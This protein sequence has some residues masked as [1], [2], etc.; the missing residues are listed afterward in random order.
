MLIV[1]MGL[2]LFVLLNAWEGRAQIAGLTV[3]LYNSAHVSPGDLVLAEERAAGIFRQAKIKINWDLVPLAG[4]V[5][6]QKASEVWNPADLHLRLWT[7]GMVGMNTFGKDTLGFCVSMEKG[8]AIII[9]DEISSR[10][11]VDFANPGDLLGLVMAHEIGHLLLRSPA[12][13]VEGIMQARLPTNL[14]DRRKMLL[15][16]SRQQGTFIRAEIHRR[17][18]VQ[19]ARKY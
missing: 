19:S 2:V 7:L 9:A 4:S 17:A 15:T 13:S 11:A 5:V 16:F 3:R 6:D 12:H 18:G 8:T 10:A 1:R 14:R